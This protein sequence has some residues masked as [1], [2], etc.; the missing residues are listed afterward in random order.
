MTNCCAKIRI[1]RINHCSSKCEVLFKEKNSC[2]SD[3]DLKEL[4][5]S[6]NEG[7]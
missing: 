5:V 7:K 3:K 1:S 2:V 4:I 6:V